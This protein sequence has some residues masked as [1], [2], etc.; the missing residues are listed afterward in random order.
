VTV[1]YLLILMKFMVQL[2]GWHTH[3]SALRPGFYTWCLHVRWA[4]V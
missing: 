3:L 2:F 4:C 1:F